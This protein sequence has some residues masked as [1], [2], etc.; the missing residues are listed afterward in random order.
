M[1]K[2]MLHTD[3]EARG[4]GRKKQASTLAKTLP[5]VVIQRMKKCGRSNCK[6]AQGELHGPY[7]YRYWR[8]GGRLRL[9]Y[10]KRSNLARITAACKTRQVQ[11]LRE[12]TEMG[13]INERTHSYRMR[14]RDLLATLR[15][16]ER[17]Q[18]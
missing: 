9:Q 11:E 5:G 8:E 1:N 6:C 2:K 12:R 13:A 10:V 16:L 18:L 14:W 3:Q 7:H 17:G 15:E 4:R